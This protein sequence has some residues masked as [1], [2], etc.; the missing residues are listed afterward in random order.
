MLQRPPGANHFF[1]IVAVL[2]IVFL[3][4]IGL[5][6]FLLSRPRV[7][8]YVQG[9]TWLTVVIWWL[10]AVLDWAVLSLVPSLQLGVGPPSLAWVI[11]S[12]GA[13][14][15]LLLTPTFFTLAASGLWLGV[16]FL[17]RFKGSAPL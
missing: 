2:A 9:A 4:A 11:V 8:A 15:L 12:L 1:V 7:R 10:V 14:S 13:I 5:V 17:G 3:L 16:R 6:V